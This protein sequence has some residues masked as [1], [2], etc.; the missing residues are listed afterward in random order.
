MP[1]VFKPKPEQTHLMTSIERGQIARITPA[2]V[3]T[4]LQEWRDNPPDDEYVNILDA[5]AEVP[6]DD[7]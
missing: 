4:A 6:T 1:D 3:E 5:A 2:D 7:D